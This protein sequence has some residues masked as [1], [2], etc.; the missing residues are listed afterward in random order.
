[1]QHFE[2]AK[3]LTFQPILSG[4]DGSLTVMGVD[5]KFPTAHGCHL[6]FRAS[7]FPDHHSVS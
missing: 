3:S 6:C 1:M 7:P 4:G 2:K 5:V